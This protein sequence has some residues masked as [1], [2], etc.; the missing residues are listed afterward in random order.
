VN[1]DSE[2]F[3]ELNSRMVW[4]LMWAVL[5]L[6]MA[7]FLLEY[8]AAS[9]G[10]TTH[11]FGQPKATQLAAE[12]PSQEVYGPSANFP[13]RSRLVK[14]EKNPRTMR[15]WLASSSHAEDVRMPVSDLFVSVL[16]TQLRQ[17]GI[18]CEVLNASRAGMTLEQNTEQLKAL[19]KKWKPDVVD[20]TPRIANFPAI[21]GSLCRANDFV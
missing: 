19:A 18:P 15:I 4:P 8:R 3:T 11:L 9:R 20:R 21:Y 16:E 17:Q 2:R 5:L 14:F 12:D 6:A 13:F 7:E 1:R 10:F